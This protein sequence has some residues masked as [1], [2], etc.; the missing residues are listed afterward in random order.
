MEHI[1]LLSEFMSKGR[2]L[3]LV[4]RRLPVN[5]SYVEGV[6]FGKTFV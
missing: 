6:A 2:R 5:W 1:R 3:A 4:E